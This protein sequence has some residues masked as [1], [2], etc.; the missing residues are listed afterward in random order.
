MDFEGGSVTREQVEALL[1]KLQR[2]E[3]QSDYSG[4]QW[5]VPCEDGEAGEYVRFDDVREMLEG[6]IDATERG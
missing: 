4:G 1:S 3:Q 6:M 5:V 2:H